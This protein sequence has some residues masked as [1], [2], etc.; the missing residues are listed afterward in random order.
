M[1]FK[2]KEDEK[3]EILEDNRGTYILNSKDMNLIEHIDKLAKADVT[4][5]VYTEF[6]EQFEFVAWLA[7]ILLVVDI[8]IL[9]GKSRFTRNIKLFVK[10]K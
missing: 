10:E 7:L 5:E 1:I 6:D 4:T 8:L 3:F 9:P 2:D